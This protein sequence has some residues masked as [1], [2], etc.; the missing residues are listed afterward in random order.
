MEN[1]IKAS[2]HL[3]EPTKTIYLEF[4]KKRFPESEHY[5]SYDYAMEWVNRF[6]GTPTIYMDNISLDIYN[7]I[8]KEK[9]M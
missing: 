7:Q 6:R 8:I 4:M 5:I 3:E 1:V 2:E 9:L